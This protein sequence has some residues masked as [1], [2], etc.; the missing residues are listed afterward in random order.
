M[1][2]EI[3]GVHAAPHDGIQASVYNRRV[4]VSGFRQGGV[5]AL[6]LGEESHH[7]R[8]QLICAQIGGVSPGLDRR[9]DRMRLDA[10][11]IQVQAEGRVVSAS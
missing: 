5:D 9:W 3:T 7:N 2:I 11:A 1:S 10:M 6:A 4:V 8:T